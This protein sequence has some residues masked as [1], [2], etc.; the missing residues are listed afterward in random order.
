MAAFLV[1][2]VDAGWRRLGMHVVVSDLRKY[3]R[4]RPSAQIQSADVEALN[5]SR[6]YV[7]RANG[8]PVPNDCPFCP[9]NAQSRFAF[10]L[11]TVAA[12]PDGNPVTEGHFLIVPL[13][14]IPDYFAMSEDERRDTDRALDRL[15]AAISIDDPKV[16]GFNVGMNCGE[17][18]GQTVHHAHIHLIPRRQGDT[19]NPRG[20][21]RG[22]VPKKMAY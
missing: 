7:G 19:E 18:A 2:A 20:G 10:T 13:R 5:R 1:R 11:G 6:M 9:A 4:L 15:R 3:R 17:V 21:V 16:E 22:V 12:F 8:G 14:H